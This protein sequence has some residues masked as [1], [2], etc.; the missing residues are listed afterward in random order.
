MRRW[1][2]RRKTLLDLTASKKSAN[3]KKKKCARQKVTF[4]AT[5]AKIKELRVDIVSAVQNE[6]NVD[7]IAKMCI[8]QRHACILHAY[9]T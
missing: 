5:H 2:R 8:A 3:W 7:D 4:F 6:Q 9:S 1:R